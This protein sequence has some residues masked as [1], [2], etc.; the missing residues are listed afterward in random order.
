[1]DRNAICG[2]LDKKGLQLFGATTIFNFHGLLRRVTLPQPFYRVQFA[3]PVSAVATTT[4]ADSGLLFYYLVR[5]GD[6]AQPTADDP[7]KLPTLSKAI[8]FRFPKAV[9]PLVPHRLRSRSVKSFGRSLS[10]QS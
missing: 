7:P 2:I 3:K 8:G 5:V 1:M 6:V 9:D 10:A 4:T